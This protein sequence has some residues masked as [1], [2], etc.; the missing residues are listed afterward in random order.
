MVLINNQ[1]DVELSEKYKMA[2]NMAA[3]A[4]VNSILFITHF[5]LM[6]FHNFGI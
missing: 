2:A 6:L 5:V 1:E 3:M 4:D